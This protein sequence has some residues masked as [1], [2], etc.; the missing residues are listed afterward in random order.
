MDAH[1]FLEVG[2]TRGDGTV[3]D[4]CTKLVRGRRKGS[5]MSSNSTEGH[6]GSRIEVVEAVGHVPEAR[7]VAQLLDDVRHTE[8]RSVGSSLHRCSSAPLHAAGITTLY[9][10]ACGLARLIQWQCLFELKNKQNMGSWP[11][12]GEA[13]S[14]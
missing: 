13:Q 8:P 6:R 1:G 9:P 3:G 7:V 2:A 11:V 5:D 12:H 14:V 10:L 4:G